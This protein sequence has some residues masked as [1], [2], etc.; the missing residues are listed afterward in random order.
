MTILAVYLHMQIASHTFWRI[1]IFS[2]FKSHKSISAIRGWCWIRD[3][4]NACWDDIMS[5]IKSLWKAWGTCARVW[6]DHL[7]VNSKLSIWLVPQKLWTA[8]GGS[9]PSLIVTS[10]KTPERWDH[11]SF[12]MYIGCLVIWKTIKIGWD[13]VTGPEIEISRNVLLLIWGA[14]PSPQALGKR[15]KIRRKSSHSPEDF[16]ETS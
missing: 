5:L 6:R 14:L 8:L 16:S 11:H 4:M 9:N 12:L 10:W 15:N 2:T 7:C 1:W 3:F 13:V